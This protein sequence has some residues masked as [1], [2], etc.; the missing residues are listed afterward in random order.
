MTQHTFSQR[1]KR[2]YTGFFPSRGHM[3]EKIKKKGKKGKK[4]EE[5]SFK[6]SKIKERL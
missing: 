4:R 2:I 1:E 3:L 6:I 5:K